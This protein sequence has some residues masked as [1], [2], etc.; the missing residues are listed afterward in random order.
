MILNKELN[1]NKYLKRLIISLY[2]I[3]D[4]YVLLDGLVPNLIYLNVTICQSTAYKRSSLS[5]PRPDKLMSY[6]LEFDLTTNENVTLNFDQL[7]YIIMLL[8]QLNKFTLN[9]KE[10][11]NNNNQKLEIL[12]QQYLSKLQY[13]HCFIQIMNNI[14]VQNFVTLN[15]LCWPIKC[16]SNSNHL[17]K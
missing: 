16:C 13:F 12:F 2:D 9:I 15:E 6:L 14:D 17:K 4:L 5:K 8:N 7:C 3:N 10:L 11:I 1:S